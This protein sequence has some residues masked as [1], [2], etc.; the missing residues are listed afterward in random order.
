MNA[1]NKICGWE[2]MY[3]YAITPSLWTQTCKPN[4]LAEV[5]TGLQL[6]HSGCASSLQLTCA[7]RLSNNNLLLLSF[8]CMIKMLI[9]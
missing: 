6:S 5:I 4:T 7:L 1:L 8:S 2:S 3:L 9:Q